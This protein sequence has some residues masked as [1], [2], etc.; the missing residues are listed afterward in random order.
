[1]DPEDKFYLFD[2]AATI[3]LSFVYVFLEQKPDIS[4]CVCTNRDRL[5]SFVC[6]GSD[7]FWDSVYSLLY[8]VMKQNFNER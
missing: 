1:M 4:R 6:G 5:Q 2:A 8:G 3:Y 7:Y